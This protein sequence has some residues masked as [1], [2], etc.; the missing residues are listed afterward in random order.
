VI[1]IRAEDVESIDTA[2]LQLLI[3]FVNEA[4]S[5]GKSIKWESCSDKLEDSSGLLAIKEGLGIS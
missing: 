4:K 1:E 2:A 3:S 5:K